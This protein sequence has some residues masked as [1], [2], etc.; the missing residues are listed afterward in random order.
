MFYQNKWQ[1]YAEK[2]GEEY[3]DDII[4]SKSD[5]KFKQVNYGYRLGVQFFFDYAKS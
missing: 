4:P 5:D 1:Y 2:I 3:D